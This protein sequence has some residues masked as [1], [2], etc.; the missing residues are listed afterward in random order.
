MQTHTKEKI[1]TRCGPEFGDKDHSIVLNTSADR[2]RAM[3]A[4][5]LRTFEFPPSRYGR[6]A[7]TRL[8][9]DTSGYDYIYAHVDVFKFVTNDPSI[10]TDLIDSIFILK[11]NGTRN[12]YLGNGYT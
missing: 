10:C 1:Y 12:H 5:F 4:E 3:L 8:R 11:E 9:N 2:F 6:D 7:W